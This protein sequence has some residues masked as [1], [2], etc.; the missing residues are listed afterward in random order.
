MDRISQR[1]ILPSAVKS[2]GLGNIIK[3]SE[4]FEASGTLD[5]GEGGLFT[6]L[7]SNDKDADLITESEFSFWETSV[8]SAN[9]IP[10]GSAIDASQYQIIGPWNEWTGVATTGGNIDSV[11]RTSITASR[12]YI[13]NI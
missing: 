12:I 8:S 5:N 7:F 4:N 9:L 11:I 10:N 1:D 6:L 2:R 13:G 3:V